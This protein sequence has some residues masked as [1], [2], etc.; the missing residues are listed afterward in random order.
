MA[1][2]GFQRCHVTLPSA[3]CGIAAC[4]HYLFLLFFSI[5]RS[6]PYSFDFNQHLFG[7]EMF[8]LG[9]R[10]N[11]ILIVQILLG[12][13][14]SFAPLLICGM[15]SSSDKSAIS[16]L[17]LPLLCVFIRTKPWLLSSR[18]AHDPNSI[19]GIPIEAFKKNL[20]RKQ[21]CNFLLG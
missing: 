9:R 15:L 16:S 13:R 12:A 14:S 10:F 7:K 21:C 11:K 20:R 8:D 6:F 18:S 3:L 2:F 17:L 19:L 5:F 4:C 1:V